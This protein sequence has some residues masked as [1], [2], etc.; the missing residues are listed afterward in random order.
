MK[1]LIH[2]K[3]KKLFSNVLI[4]MF[5]LAMPSIMLAQNQKIKLTGKNITLKM[6][7]EQIERQT[8]LSID[9]DAKTID[10]TKVIKS[11]PKSNKLHEVMMQ[12]LQGTNSKF[13]INQSHVIITVQDV[14]RKTTSNNELQQPK[15]I[16]GVVTDNNGEPL[17]GAS[18]IV[19]GTGKGTMTDLNGKYRIETSKGA[20]LTISYIGYNNQ[21]V[22]IEDNTVVNI[23]LIENSKLLNEVVAIGYGLQKRVNMIGSIATIDA[24]YIENRPLTT[25]SAG[26][27]GLSAGVSVRQGSGKPGSDNGNILIRGAG[28]LNNTV[29]LVIIDGVVGSIDAVN[30]NDVENISVLKDASTAAIYGSLASN[31]VILVTTKKGSKNK[32]TV[33][34]SGQ[35][36]ITNPSNIPDFISDYVRQMQLVNEGST[37]LGQSPVYSA[38]TIAAWQKSN[39]DPNGLT[40]AGIPNYIAYPNTNWSKVIFQNNVLQSHNVSVNGGNDNTQYLLSGYFLDDPGTMPNTGSSKYQLRINLQSKINNFLTIG[41]QTFGSIQTYK[42]G[43]TSSA[44]NNMTQTVPGIYPEY[45]GKYGAPSASEEAVNAN[46]IISAL[47]S[48]GGANQLSRLNTTLFANVN[49]FKGL[50]FESKFHYDNSYTENNKHNTPYEI[51]NFATNTLVRSSAAPTSLTTTYNVSRNYSIIFDDV[52]RYNTTIAN[53]HDIGVMVGYNQQYF[54][55]Y[56]IGA[57]KT[58]LIDP[59]IATFNSA[60]TLTS[61]NGDEYD[62]AL[63]SVFGRI[64]YAY[65][66]R[67]LFESV[68]RYDGSS[69]FAAADRWGIFPAF[70]AGWRLSEES[71]MKNIKKIVD[72]LK[73]RASWGKTG[74][75]ASGNYDYQ[76]T[77]NSTPYSFNATATTGL[78]QSKISNPALQWETTT[79]TN[80]GLDGTLLNNK[81]RFETDIYNRNTNGIL[82]VPTI[83]ITVGT[84]T[85][86]T[87]NIAEVLN[88]GIEVTL[89]YRGE[90]G[91]FKYEVSANLAYNFNSVAKYKGALQEGYTTDANGNSVYTSNL[92]SVSSGGSTRIVEG[93]IINEIYLYPIYK[94][95]GTYNNQDGSINI[96]GG[97][98]DGM[99]RTPED[100]AWL[101]SMTAAGYSF[102]PAGGIGKTKIWYGDLIYADTNGDKIYGNTFDKTF[103][104]KS[105]LPKYNYGFNMNLAYKSF[106][107]FMLWSGS[108]GMYYYDNYYNPNVGL[109]HSVSNLIANDHYYYNDADSS[110]PANNIGAHYPRLKTTDA[111]NGLDSY[112]YL[113]NASYLKLK[114]LQIGYTIPSTVTKKIAINK[115]KIYVS[116]ENLLTITKYPGIDPEIGSGIGYPTMRTYTFGLNVTF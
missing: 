9:Y 69:R 67:Y 75:N 108:A 62:Y 6:A 7:F 105:G 71:F 72:N 107:M 92:G 111:Q 63:R 44:F 54:N 26:L 56:N 80:L 10:I 64:N 73:V 17:L 19:N 113:Y 74:N 115:A 84:A 39:A 41:T 65:K 70:S 94:G 79:T 112:F 29:P 89:N 38:T 48:L 46:N 12:L 59:S 68:L 43:D 116:G 78:I 5:L 99:I 90:F 93:H 21:Q 25:L 57:V 61:I 106:D 1:F 24:K 11:I 8:G 37:N 101:Q 14:Q 81:L 58:G 2:M 52:L 91:K 110:D 51:W 82:F 97:P 47:Y 13:I 33:T 32:I 35:A 66:Q 30:P 86:A 23:Q 95:S 102:R 103:S 34:Y 104:G 36:A 27:T 42:L 87:R 96:N 85:A 3:E 45:Q 31:G 20:V 15:I 22:I 98:K 53:L 40:A 49:I 16:S 4:L 77:Y 55:N 88:K 114:N 28:T 76:A 100:M 18:V 83:P 109:G 60:T 50:T